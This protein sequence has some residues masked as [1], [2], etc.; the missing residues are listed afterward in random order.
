MN[1]WQKYG[2]PPRQL[3]PHFGDRQVRCFG[4]RP[5][6]LDEMFSRSVTSFPD[7]EAVVCNGQRWTYRETGQIVDRIAASFNARGMGK[8]DRIAM[9]IPNRAEFVFALLAIQRLGAI[10]VPIGTREQMPGITYMLSQSGARAILFDEVFADRIPDVSEVPTLQARIPLGLLGP[11]ASTPESL[12]ATAGAG[13]PPPQLDEEDVAVILY[14]SGTTGNPKGAMLTQLNIVHSALH[15]ESCLRLQANERAGLAVP[16]SHVTGLIAIIAAMVRVAGTI[17]V[18]PEFKA[19]EF[20]ELAEREKMTFTLM[21]PA[22]YNLCLLQPGIRERNLCAWRIGG[23]GGAPMPVASI[24]ALAQVLPN[25]T[26]VN[27]YGATETTSPTTIMPFGLIREHSDSVGV[28][29]PCADI[30]VM[31]DVGHEVP[32]GES[33]ELWIGGPM[34]VPGYWNN[35]E[36]TASSFTDG[37]WHSGDIGSVDA[38]GFVRVFDRKKDMLNRGGYKIYSVEVENVLMSMKGVT[39]AA[40]VGK[41]CPMLGERVHAFVSV[42]SADITENTLREHCR[43]HLADYKVPETILVSRQPLPRNANGKLLKRHLRKKLGNVI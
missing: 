3:E 17:I 2:V 32:P 22:M 34:V 19:V 5:R 37:Y 4:Q 40:V 39:E 1:F 20:L 6:S 18:V 41:P 30:R 36:A 29:L 35:P 16:A 31:D 43:K 24:D 38:E 25:L 26:L 27:A 23:F 8:G 28:A 15:Y 10:A 12:M 21:V 42:P 33:G 11:V 9:F 7:N 13:E 14:T